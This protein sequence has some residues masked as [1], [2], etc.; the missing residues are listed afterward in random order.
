LDRRGLGRD[1]N[2]PK[3]VKAKFLWICASAIAAGG[4]LYIIYGHCN[5]GT[6]SGKP[7][8]T[9]QFMSSLTMTLARPLWATLL[10]VITT[11]CYYGYLPVVDGFFSHWVWHPFVKLTYGTYLLHIVVIKTFAGNMSGYFHYS[12][13][14]VLLHAFGFFALTYMASV[15]MWC[16]IEKP[17]AALTDA[18]V[19]KKKPQQSVPSSGLDQKN[20]E[21]LLD[22]SPSQNETSAAISKNGAVLDP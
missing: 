20:K 3:T 11:A 15:V 9:R 5:G 18:L 17:F 22:V 8:N 2:T 1:D 21:A 12:L 4:M 10:A 13:S 7:S 14:E 16:L 6:A 19:P